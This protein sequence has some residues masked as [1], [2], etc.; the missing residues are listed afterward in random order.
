MGAQPRLQAV[1][2]AD[3]GELAIASCLNCGYVSEQVNEQCE[4]CG[5]RFPQEN[6]PLRTQLERLQ[7]S[8]VKKNETA[9]STF[10]TGKF[11]RLVFAVIAALST[12]IWAI[13]LIS[14]AVSIQ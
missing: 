8:E 14:R 12:T 4:Q 13:Y 7:R 11:S 9:R 1:R 6:T 5:V 2:L 10:D 3:D